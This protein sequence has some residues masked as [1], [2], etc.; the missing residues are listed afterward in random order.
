[1]D[2]VPQGSSVYVFF[3]ARIP[4]WVAIPFSRA[5][6]GDPPDPGMVPTSPVSPAFQVGSF[7]AEPQGK[8]SFP[9][10]C[11]LNIKEH[12]FQ[13]SSFFNSSLYFGEPYKWNVDLYQRTWDFRHYSSQILDNA[14]EL[15][16]VLENGTDIEMQ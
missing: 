3:P 6:P 12:L 4:E 14:T 15:C 13:G 16:H 10:D 1:M 5:S 2:C 9:G 11:L 8:P 7:I